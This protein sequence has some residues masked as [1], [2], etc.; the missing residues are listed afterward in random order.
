MK[1]GEDFAGGA[2]SLIDQILSLEVLQRPWKHKILVGY[3][4]AGLFTLYTCTKTDY[5][6]ACA[7][8]S[9][10]LWFPNWNAYLQSHPLHVNYAYLSLGDLEAKTK[11]P[12]TSKVEEETQKTYQLLQEQSIQTVFEM[13]QGN[14]FFESD[15]RIH[16]AIK[17]IIENN[18]Q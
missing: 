5:F 1:K 2:D 7:S 10:S 12:I 13:N 17:N 9:G 4:L 18:S 16:K 14:H 11:N 6:E 8:V 3:S 15:A